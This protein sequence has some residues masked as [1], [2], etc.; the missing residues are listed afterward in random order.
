MSEKQTRWRLLLGAQSEESID[1]SESHQML[2]PGSAESEIDEVLE[3][4]YEN[5][6]RTGG[7]G[8]S[9]LSVNKWLSKIRIH[10]SKSAVRVIQKD[11]I[12]I[13]GVKEM[14]LEPETLE[15]LE[16][17][18]HL[19]SQLIALKDM[20]PEKTLHAARG[21]VEKIVNDIQKKLSW[22]LQKSVTG[23]LNKSVPKTHHLKLN[24]IH[25]QKTILK[26][27]KNFQPEL[28]TIIPEKIFGFGRKVSKMNE[29]VL[30]VDQSGSMGNSMVFSSITA[31]AL[32]SV[33][34]LKTHL[35]AFDAHTVDLTPY[36]NDPVSLLFAAQLSGGTDIGNALAVALTKIQNPSRTTLI[37]ISD[38][39]EGGEEKVMY[40]YFAL[41]KHHQVNV[42]VLPALDDEGIPAFDQ[43]VAKNIA[44]MN[45]PVF[46]CTPDF[47]PDLLAITL[48]NKNLFEISDWGV[49]IQRKN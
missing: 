49:G 48:T 25:W 41:L 28:N 16:S 17:D 33:P 19:V 31:A 18:V 13:L 44:G 35:I 39:F 42:I 47:L 40:Q 6:K 45:I 5:G 37:L 14:L 8:D 29:L 21:V 9:N 23:S 30:L 7:L 43:T 34:S 11:A 32:A 27:L 26:N 15:S 10:F 22:K 38:L 4:L 24:D 36:I 46:S 12:D 20:M 3:Q 2:Q 1:S